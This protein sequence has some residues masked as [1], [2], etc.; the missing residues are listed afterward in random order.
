MA[1]NL[2]SA[3]LALS[4]AC[5]IQ[6]FLPETLL[7]QG[8]K[9]KGTSNGRNYTGIQSD[10]SSQISGTNENLESKVEMASSIKFDRNTNGIGNTKQNDESDEA[11]LI[12]HDADKQKSKR[13]PFF[14]CDKF[15]SSVIIACIIYCFHSFN[16][17]AMSEV[18]PLWLLSGQNDGGLNLTA[19]Y[20]GTI[21]SFVGFSLLI[22]QA[23]VYPWLAK[24]YSV[25]DLMK[26]SML[27]LAPCVFLTPFLSALDSNVA[28]VLCTILRCIQ[29]CLVMC[30]FTATFL[31]INNASDDGNRG[32]S[33]GLAM[34]IGSVSKGL[35]PI[36]ASVLFAWSIN[37]DNVFPFDH[38]FIF[39]VI[40]ILTFT[41]YLVLRSEIIPKAKLNG[42]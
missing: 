21:I 33:N 41:L 37:N 32:A 24:R 9:C 20:I 3:F 38:H 8:C 42:D 10:E 15:D 35:G 18:Y 5:M 40:S 6:C 17:I 34:L 23:F 28:V 22:F 31:A 7:R 19:S 1:P 12:I 26:H 39:F 29:M 25:T 30:M 36:V 14:R 4:G 16:A 2:L 11:Q 13:C 27:G